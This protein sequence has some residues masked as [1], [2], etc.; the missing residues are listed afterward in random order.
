MKEDDGI[1]SPVSVIYYDFYDDVQSVYNYI[2][3]NS[4]K[5]QCVVSKEHVPFGSAQNPSLSDYADNID[6][7]DSLVKT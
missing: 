7:I 2:S 1:F 4:D 6:I 5:I 3:D